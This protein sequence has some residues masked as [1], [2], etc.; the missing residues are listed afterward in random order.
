MWGTVAWALSGGCPGVLGW[1]GGGGW[2]GGQLPQLSEVSRLGACLRASFLQVAQRGREWNREETF[3]TLPASLLSPLPSLRRLPSLVSLSSLSAASQSA[4][5]HL[6][7]AHC[8]HRTPKGPL[9]I[10][11]FIT[12]AFFPPFCPCRQR[13]RLLSSW[14][15]LK[16]P[17]VFSEAWDV[18]PRYLEEIP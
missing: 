3:E 6:L 10:L 15:Y 7:H 2:R 8:V 11:I 14:V 18:E 13:L 16:S 4:I 17:E 9:L 1:A 5:S 12:T